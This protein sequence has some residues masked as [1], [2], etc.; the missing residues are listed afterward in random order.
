MTTLTNTEATTLPT[1]PDELQP[2]DVLDELPG[3][4]QSSDLDTFLHNMDANPGKWVVLEVG[5]KQNAA[6]SLAKRRGFNT[7][8]YEAVTRTVNGKLTL[9]GRRNPTSF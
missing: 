5:V 3:R 7:D 6:Q 9:F 4:A 8:Q 1:L 2:G